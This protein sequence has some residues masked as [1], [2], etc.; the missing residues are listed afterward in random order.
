M[1]SRGLIEGLEARIDVMIGYLQVAKDQG[2]VNPSE[3]VQIEE[4][5]NKI[6]QEIFE[7]SETFEGSDFM[8]RG[9]NVEE[10]TNGDISVP[11]MTNTLLTERQKVVIN[12]L[13]EHGELQIKQFQKV[14]SEVT[15]R[16][17]RRD[18]KDLLEKE[19]V[20]RLGQGNE[21]VYRLN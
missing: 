14:L 10:N 7:I 16:T 9:T 18:L 1:K 20:I 8:Q 13:E 6:R 17:L 2:W 15:K 21:T 4:E 3:I 5:Y 12:L 19:R 11:S